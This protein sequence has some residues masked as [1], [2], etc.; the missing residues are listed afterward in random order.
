MFTQNIIIILVEV[1]NDLVQ[2]K[3]TKM[4]FI[5]KIDISWIDYFTAKKISHVILLLVM[6]MDNLIL[7]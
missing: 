1:M 3:C 4:V 2:L 6:A 5:I 7:F